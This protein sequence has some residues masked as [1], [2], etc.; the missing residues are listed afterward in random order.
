MIKNAVKDSFDNEKRKAAVYN[1]HHSQMV[2]LYIKS[3]A[4]SMIDTAH[5][6]ATDTSL[7]ENIGMLFS[8]S[9]ELKVE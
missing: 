6:R 7:D 2:L 9:S 1:A 8:K 4:D 3:I 5:K